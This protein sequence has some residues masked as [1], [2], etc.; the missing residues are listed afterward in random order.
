MEQYKEARSRALRKLQIADHMLT[1]TYPAVKDP[2]LLLSVL[3][4]LFLALTNGMAAVLHYEYANKNI[5]EFQ[6]TFESKYNLFKFKVVDRRG[7][8]KDYVKF[9][10]EVKDIIV[11]HKNSPVEFSRKDTF[12]ICTGNYG[13]QTVT[14]NHLKKY[15]T[16][17]KSFLQEIDSIID[18]NALPPA[19]TEKEKKN[20]FGNSGWT[21][22]NRLMED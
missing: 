2:K 18:P 3:E 16:K 22:I 11:N 14:A 4:N 7:I 15:V 20:P 9:I 5:P 1:Q 21:D 10:A 13:I 6:D 8:D 17:T 12:V 19:E